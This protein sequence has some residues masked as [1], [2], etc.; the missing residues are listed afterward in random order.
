MCNIRHTCKALIRELKGKSPLNKPRR[1]CEHNIK[2]NLKK[3]GMMDSEDWRHM[4]QDRV[5]RRVLVKTVMTFD[6]IKDR[7]FIDQLSD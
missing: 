7:Q 1:R 3:I 4:A 5:Q 6:F 2:R